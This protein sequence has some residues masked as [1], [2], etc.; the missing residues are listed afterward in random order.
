MVLAVNNM[1]NTA[2]QKYLQHK[3][4]TDTKLEDP[5]AKVLRNREDALKRKMEFCKEMKV[6]PEE[7]DNLKALE[8]IKVFE[9]T[10]D[11]FFAE[12]EEEEDVFLE[13][14]RNC[15][16]VE[17]FSR[18]EVLVRVSM[19]IAGKLREAVAASGGLL[20]QEHNGWVMPVILYRDF[21]RKVSYIKNLTFKEVPDF[22]VRALSQVMPFPSRRCVHDYRTDRIRTLADLPPEMVSNMYPFQREGVEYAFSRYGR[23]L[24]GDEMGVG[25]TIQGIATATAFIE[26]W[27]VLVLCPA[28]VKL[29]WRDE[30]LKWVKGL[31][32]KDFYILESRLSMKNAAKVWIA[33]YTMATH[34]EAF[35]GSKTFNVVIVDESHY[36]KNYSAKRTQSLLPIIQRAKRV[37]LLSGTP[38]LARPSE[39][40]TQLASVRPDIFYSFK[41]FANRYCDPKPQYN[42]IDYTGASHIKE[43]H[44]L[45]SN[46]VMIRRLKVD[47]LTQLPPKRRQKVEI[48]VSQEHCRSIKKLYVEVKRQKQY[49]SEMIEALGEEEAKV[50]AKKLE[51]ELFMSRAYKLTGQAKVRGVCE[52]V[53][54]LLQ[55]DCKFI[56]FAHHLE[57]LDSIEQQVIKDKALYIRIDGS[58]SQER[59]HKGIN[60]FQTM[61]DCRVAILGI[62]AAGQGITLTA[63]ATVVMAEMTWTPGIMI[64]AEDRAHRI[65][66]ERCVNI[67]YLYGPG[68]LDEYIWPKIR[69]KLNIIS[70]TLDNDQNETM[71][72]LLNPPD[73][74]GIGD[75]NVEED[76]DFL[77]KLEEDDVKSEDLS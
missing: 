74:L 77:K 43:L 44:T 37:I 9:D 5:L 15:V 4:K 52:Y 73:K 29:N 42:I 41:V 26:E 34:L 70:G 31:E 66:Q 19:F 48:G 14:Q 8:P 69:S 1:Q 72:G 57:I 76:L 49:F 56:I 39:L 12:K 16:E 40:Y 27:P 36:L 21:R 68:T 63:A 59:R 2:F 22:V 32:E 35:L 46:T 47:V 24:I 62:L 71:R 67:H 55:S 65:G 33:S 53:S 64:Q 75:F 23:V 28:C 60:A 51:T 18:D 20:S 3:L 54:Y 6:E 30:F 11:T 10:Y 61:K 25:K 50:A 58:T 17:L 38:V 7:V 45:L 13:D